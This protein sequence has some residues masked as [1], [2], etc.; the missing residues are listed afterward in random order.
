MKDEQI[1]DWLQ[2]AKVIA[3][4]GH[5]SNPER[6]SYRIASYLRESGYAVLPVN[7][8]VETID[9]EKSYNSLKDIKEKVNYPIIAIA[10][11]VALIAYFVKLPLSHEHQLLLM[12]FEHCHNSSAE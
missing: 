9:G 10:L 8:S 6:T 12:L 2:E 7:P 1:R 4:V 11:G 5:S 3:V